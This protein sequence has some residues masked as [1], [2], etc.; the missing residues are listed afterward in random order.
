MNNKEE[1]II[2]QENNVNM[3]SLLIVNN[4]D[5]HLETSSILEQTIDLDMNATNY[6]FNETL[7]NDVNIS[8]ISV[9][10]FFDDLPKYS[11]QNEQVILD[12]KANESTERLANNV[13]TSSSSVNSFD[14][15]LQRSSSEVRNI[16]LFEDE[17]LITS[18]STILDQNNSSLVLNESSVIFEESPNVVIE[19]LNES[20]ELMVNNLNE[21][22]KE[23]NTQEYAT[24]EQPIIT[25]CSEDVHPSENLDNSA[26]EGIIIE[27]YTEVPLAESQNNVTD[28]NLEEEII[29]ENKK[30]RPRKRKANQEFWERNIRKKHRLTGESYVTAKGKVMPEKVFSVIENCNCR[31][32]CH[33]NIPSVQ[34]KDLFKEYYR[35]GDSC[36]Q[37]AFLSTLVLEK[38]ILRK[39]K[40]NPDK[41]G[42]EKN[43]SRFYFLPDSEREKHRVCLNFFCKVFQISF[44]VIDLALMKSSSSGVYTGTDGRKGRPAPNATKPEV[45]C[46]VKKTY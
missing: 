18:E 34:Q 11:Y 20:E 7:E 19:I 36:R 8:N 6:R 3:P 25:T 42:K 46:K 17:P 43:K 31:F 5:Y 13:N 10:S 40:R 14:A 26:L 41:T 2:H 38:P 28:T 39:R 16:I 32:K 4:V 33:K 29:C 30:N 44:Q 35:L 24:Q 45:V 15:N 27:N 21:P 37:K 23:I 9:N 12:S 22:N 1:G